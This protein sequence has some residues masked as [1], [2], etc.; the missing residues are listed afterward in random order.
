MT[1]EQQTQGG[2]TI[3]ESIAE[4]TDLIR[5]E[6]E[7]VQEIVTRFA[8]KQTWDAHTDLITINTALIEIVE[9]YIAKK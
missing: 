6:I 5:D 1:T 4:T 9:T 2:W 3:E 8:S 7:R